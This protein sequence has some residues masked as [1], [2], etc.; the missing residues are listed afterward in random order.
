M[1]TDVARSA[2]CVR[3]RTANHA[4]V[5][6]CAACGE[7]LPGMTGKQLDEGDA[8]LASAGDRLGAAIVD[9][10][11]VAA[12]CVLVGVIVARI[13]GISGAL[14]AQSD[15]EAALRW[16]FAVAIGFFVSGAVFI[17][18][19]VIVLA[20]IASSGQSPGKKAVNIKIVKSHGR[21]TPGWGT[22]L[23][24]EI[25]GKLVL[26]FTLGPVLGSALQ[27]EL[28]F[29]LGLVL[30]FALGLVL[31]SPLLFVSIL[32]DDR[33][34]GWHDKIADTYVVKIKN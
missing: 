31:G 13:P 5:R 29:A 2:E 30:G 32:I 1:T 14:G 22:A 3:C 16:L 21:R 15:I 28:G 19:Y 12:I 6:Y 4:G 23:K 18:Y 26:G 20:M 27:S 25:L 34:Q 24:R 7:L 11:I 17:A 10:L 8:S 9:W 33:R